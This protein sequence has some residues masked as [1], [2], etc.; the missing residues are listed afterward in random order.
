MKKWAVINDVQIPFEDKPVLWGL[1]V[2][3][4]QSL[5]LDGV[6]LNGDI[7][8]NYEISDYEKDPRHRSFGLRA[9]RKG[10]ARLLDAFASVPGKVYLAGNHEDRFRRYAWGRV[11]ELVRA[12][13][14][15]S[16]ETAFGVTARGW[17]Y[18]PYGGHIQLGKLLVTH[19]FLVAQDSGASAKR[20]FAR[21]GTSLMIGH[22]HRV[23]QYHVTN[24]SGDH[25]AYENF[26]LCRLDGF[27][28]LNYTQF[29]NWQQ[30]FSIVD[31][32]DGGLFN[33]QQIRILKRRFFLYGG[34][35]VRR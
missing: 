9:E 8:D 33:V 4:L 22:T 14:M 30:G 6:V 26:C 35:I 20:H 24:Q 31:V 16:Y 29:P 13:I 27:G 34:Q 12:D 1:V 23:G 11:P 18:K 32:F 21:L 17:E 19:G 7:V 5:K 15:P 25:A 2:P 10:V 3:F 28:G